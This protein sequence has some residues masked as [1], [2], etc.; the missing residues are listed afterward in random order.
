MCDENFRGCASDS[1]V[2]INGCKQCLLLIIVTN[3]SPFNCSRIASDLHLLFM[4]VF[5][6][7]VIFSLI[8]SLY[9][10]RFS[11]Q[12]THHRL[13]NR[14]MTLFWKYWTNCIICYK[15]LS[16][17]SEPILII[18]LRFIQIFLSWLVLPHYI[19]QCRPSGHFFA[20]CNNFGQS[21]THTKLIHISKFWTCISIWTCNV[22]LFSIHD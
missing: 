3:F 6:K 13:C 9:C 12:L 7:L 4:F 22:L 2:P 21:F 20:D 18:V 17:I 16:L 14:F 19:Q 1:K 5:A 8:I 10:H 11:T 15:M